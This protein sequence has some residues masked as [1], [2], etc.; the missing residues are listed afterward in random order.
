MAGAPPS[1]TAHAAAIAIDAHR[2][3]ARAAMGGSLTD[4]HVGAVALAIASV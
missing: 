1:G 4:P 3:P 2:R